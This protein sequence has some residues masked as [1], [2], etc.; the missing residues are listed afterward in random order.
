MS[1]ELEVK[2]VDLFYGRVQALRGLSIEVNEGE[3]V[4]LLGNNGAGK[5]STLT[6]LSGLAR[7]KSGTI[8]WRGKDIS[9]AKPWDLVRDGLIHV[10][11]GRRIFSTMSVHENLLL[12]GYQVKDPKV[13][14]DRV[15]ECY[16]LMPRLL[17]RRTQ[18]GG[19]LSGG[20]QQMVAIAR[21]YV[22]GPK[23]MLLDEPSMGLAPLVVKQVMELIG[24]INERGATVL[25]VEQNARAAL[26][27]AHRAYVIEHGHVTLSGLASDLAKDKAVIEAYLG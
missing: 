24:R 2:D 21:A 12:G 19:T 23:L 20:E 5:T 18:Q 17:E 8:T 26:K 9:S 4:S 22:G 13:V 6:M 25:L 1:A 27:V 10:P 11:E 15:E 14:A 7:A 3:V 16:E